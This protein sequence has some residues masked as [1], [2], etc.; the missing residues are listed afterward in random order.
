M[1]DDEVV[2]KVEMLSLELAFD[3]GVLDGGVGCFGSGFLFTVVETKSSKEVG[4]AAVGTAGLSS[5]TADPNKWGRT[6]PNELE[7]KGSDCF[8]MPSKSS[9]AK[10]PAIGTASPR[11]AAAKLEGIGAK[12]TGAIGPAP[13]VSIGVA[14]LGLVLFGVVVAGIAGDGLS[15]GVAGELDVGVNGSAK[16]VGLS[17]LRMKL[18]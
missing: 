6:A 16:L 8:L 14:L 1:P 17:R 10:Y 9:T 11:L 12:A 13:V 4:T 5:A 18:N 2:I 3:L 7:L 15:F